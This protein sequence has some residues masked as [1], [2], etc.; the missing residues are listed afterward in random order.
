[1]AG[2]RSAVSLR[3][4]TG[5]GRNDVTAAL[6]ELYATD[7]SDLLADAE[8]LDRSDAHAVQQLADKIRAAVR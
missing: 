7:W 6:D 3:R 8:Y 1:M 4:I 2:I 5:R